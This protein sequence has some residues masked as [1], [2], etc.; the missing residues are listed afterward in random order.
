MDKVDEIFAGNITMTDV[1]TTG[2]FA[3]ATTDATTQFVVKDVKVYEKELGTPK[4]FVNTF[5]VAN[6]A[7]DV[8][9]WEVVDHNSSLIYQAYPSAPTL[10]NQTVRL[11]AGNN[12]LV[13]ADLRFLN[14][15]LSNSV[16]NP[17]VNI[18]ISPTLPTQNHLFSQ[19]T[20]GSIFYIETDGTN[21]ISLRKR[22]GGINGTE[23]VIF[24]TS[25]SWIVFDGINTYYEGRPASNIRAYNINTNVTTTISVPSGISGN[26]PKAS[27]TND[28]KIV[29]F[30]G[31]TNTPNIIL[32]DPLT[33]LTSSV[34][35]T[36]VSLTIFDARID[37]F[38]DENTQRYTIYRKT[39]ST[40]HK[41][42]VQAT[43]VIGGSVPPTITTT[44]PTFSSNATCVTYAQPDSVN[45]KVAT[46]GVID[47][48]DLNVLNTITNGVTT[49]KFLPF[50]TNSNT[51]ITRVN[52]TASPA[53]F[54]ESTRIRVTGVKTTS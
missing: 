25:G 46:H 9:G 53:L 50:Q 6:L 34:I 52:A 27:L 29:I 15:E 41:S 2:G 32:F 24:N 14:N 51:F 31:S 16:I 23:T 5:E 26:S 17:E 4:L 38:F 22:D 48:T 11:V 54:T 43:F 39:G 3:I 36:S 35:L 40:L 47:K 8:T 13:E 33:N 42:Q 7:S 37:A 49:E 10:I 1:A 18:A 30:R 28:G 19:A 21:S 12:T 44:H 20:D 45:Y